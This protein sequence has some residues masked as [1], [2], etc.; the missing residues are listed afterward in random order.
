MTP[1]DF[2][3]IFATEL[4]SNNYVSESC[5]NALNLVMAKNV[6]AV[7][8]QDSPTG[9]AVSESKK[10]PDFGGSFGKSRS[11]DN[12]RKTPIREVAPGQE[13]LPYGAP[14]IVLPENITAGMTR[15]HRYYRYHF[16]DC[17]TNLLIYLQEQG[18]TYTEQAITMSELSG[19]AIHPQQIER[20]YKKNPQYKVPKCQTSPLA[21]KK[22]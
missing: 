19:M 22:R 18:Q 14:K 20:Y 3:K 21:A 16:L 13:T 9:T 2:I 11:L 7:P 12:K 4:R 10:T 15:G 5:K 17:N 8:S 1:E 6:P